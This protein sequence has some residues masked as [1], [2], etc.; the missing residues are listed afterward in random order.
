MADLTPAQAK[1][2]GQLLQQVMGGSGFAGFGGN[3]KSSAM[4][5]YDNDEGGGVDFTKMKNII[6]NNSDLATQMGAT[7]K[8]LNA[9]GKTVAGLYK[10]LEE[11]TRSQGNI[12][13]KAAQSM[14][15]MIEKTNDA[16][17]KLEQITRIASKAS[18]NL[19][20]SEKVFAQLDKIAAERKKLKTIITKRRNK[21]ESTTSYEN[22]LNTHNKENATKEKNLRGEAD[23]I[24]N[25]FKLLNKVTG[26]L[27]AG[28]VKQLS[29]FAKMT[30][31]QRNKSGVFDTVRKSV[32]GLDGSTKIA[33]NHI[34]TNS[35]VAGESL[36]AAG[37]SAVAFGKV[38]LTMIPG[39]YA[40]LKANQKYNVKSYNPLE[41][42]LRGMSEQ[43]RAQAIGENRIGLRGLGSGNEE[44]GFTNTK[45]L[46]ETAHIF[47]VTGAAALQKAFDYQKISMG[48]GVST[49]NVKA[50]QQQMSQM[51]AMSKAVG[52][53][54]EELQDFYATLKDTGQLA[55]M[56][57]NMSEK[58]DKD[59]SQAI[60]QEIFQ[61][62]A[63]NKAMGISVDMLKRQA[64]DAV[65]SRY[66][67]LANSIKSGL[68]EQLKIK[69]YNKDNPNDQ[70]NPADSKRMQQIKAAGVGGTS[71]ED[72][73]WYNA[74]ELKIGTFRTAKLAKDQRD[75][76]HGGKEFTKD[77]VQNQYM[78]ALNPNLAQED[79]DFANAQQQ[80]QAQ[81]KDAVQGDFS[82]VIQDASTSLNGPT[83]LTGAAMDAAQA[84]EGLAKSPL[85]GS[86]GVASYIEGA[87]AA[88]V[89]G[90]VTK[91]GAGQIAKKLGTNALGKAAADVAEHGVAGA[92]L[93]HA[94]GYVASKTPES[95]L[96]KVAGGVAGKF[97]TGAAGNVARAGLFSGIGRGLLKTGLRGGAG[98]L[99]A[100]GINSLFGGADTLSEGNKDLGSRMLRGGDEVADWAMASGW[101]PAQGVGLAYKGGVRTGNAIHNFGSKFDGYKDF[102]DTLFGSTVGGVQALMGGDK[103]GWHQA[104]KSAN[105]L[106]GKLGLG[107]NDDSFHYNGKSVDSGISIPADVAASKISD[108]TK[109]SLDDAN[110]PVALARDQETIKVLKAIAKATTESNDRD[111]SK[112]LTPE[113]PD[114]V[115]GSGFAGYNGHL[116]Q[117]HAG[118]FTR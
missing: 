113:T 83:G 17:K 47:G 111:K 87:I 70:I 34:I 35:K 118:A 82:K 6:K 78:G 16:A 10:T 64:Q 28:Q 106:A 42:G 73:A 5:K 37:Q 29:R 92:L 12:Q 103:S 36:K 60:N 25:S 41:S 19:S 61:R 63:L 14:A 109:Q 96:G 80:G 2:L 65:N 117:V 50:Q 68:G 54:D 32:E 72:Q 9:R 46:Q 67:G 26:T 88:K 105:E 27:S 33:A 115:K 107:Y 85:G 3:A 20:R 13:R 45:A 62:L 77:L 71:P 43:E 95:I 44:K 21:G 91:W 108:L 79:K 56:S 74:N 86:G 15:D 102:T 58:N 69:Q 22:E 53:T 76:P 48:M 93:K 112:D 59:R 52:S 55:G 8:D 57:A 84:L 4:H 104:E 7:Y 100:Y 1:Q 99:G 23:K 39:I 116:N 31:N 24:I 90:M 114:N 18:E 97:A 38:L 110:D 51:H 101:K 81:G 94:A 89:G 98:A 30:A 75:Y 49:S 66:A 11:A 40:G